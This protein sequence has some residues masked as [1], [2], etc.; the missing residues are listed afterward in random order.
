MALPVASDP[1]SRLG[2]LTRAPEAE[3]VM[4]LLP[5]A[6]TPPELQDEERRLAS[7]LVEIQRRA[8]DGLVAPILAE[9]SLDGA[10]GQALMSLA[11]AYLRV[12]DRATADALIA[13]KLA[14]VDWTDH[15]GAAG[16][17]SLMARGL[18]AAKKVTSADAGRGVKAITAPVVRTAVT[19]AMRQMGRFF[20]LGRDIAEALDRA[21]GLAPAVC[22]FDMLGEGARTREAADQYFNRYRD[23]INAVG[24]AARSEVP[25]I[26]RHSVSVK[27][28]ALHPR[29][30]VSQADR[31]VPELIE[32]VQA[33]AE[34]AAA[35][36]IALTIDAEE[37]ERLIMS[38]DIIGAVAKTPALR[39]WDGLGMAVQA[40]QK[41]AL[42]VIDWA[43]ETSRAS[44]RRLAVRLVKGAYW[45]AEIKRCQ[46]DGLRDY[47][48]FTRKS[49]T[50]VSYLACAR[51]MLE[52]DSLQP[53]FATHNALTLA[54]LL[55]WAGPRRDVEFQRLHGMGEELYH[56]L[57]ASGRLHLRI[58]APVGGHQDLLPYLVRRL[59]ENG[60]NSS[61]VHQAAAKDETQVTLLADPRE[62]AARHFGAP[63]PL[64]LPPSEMFG[65]ER[66]NSTGLDMA[67]R[68]QLAAISAEFIRA[69]ADRP[70]GAPLINGIAAEGASTPVCDPANFV[71]EVGRVIEARA[72]DITK[73][74]DIA[75][76]FHEEWSGLPVEVRAACL[77][78]AAD[79]M[80]RDR[81]PLMALLVREA[82]K[83][84][85]DALL[86]V[87]E[88]TDFCRY[89]AATAR[90]LMAV[91]ILPGPTG[92]RNELRLAGRGVF[93]CI[94]P[95]NFPLAIFIGQIAA[96]L[97]TGN[98]VVAKPAPQTPLIASAAIKLLLE[99]GVP[100]AAIQLLPGGTEVG[101]ALVADPRV[102]GIVFTGSTLAAKHIARAV[103]ADDQRAL[104]TLIA[105]T[106]GLNAMIVD[107][108]A[109]P[110]QV[111]RDVVISAFQ[112]AGQR[113][114]ALRLLCL[115]DDIA[116]EVI[117]ML[118]GAIAE[119]RVGEPEAI[120]T[121]V[122]PVI[123]ESARKRLTSYVASNAN[124]V[125][126]SYDK[127]LP[128]QGYYVAPCVI[129]FDRPE[130]LEREVFGPILHLVRWK[131]GELDQLIDRVNGR[132]FGLTMGVHSRIP[133][134]IEQVRK[135]ARVGNLYVNR[136]MIGAVVG[137]Q[138][139]G[140]E[141][142]S[143]T[144][145]KA[146][147]PHYLPRFCVERTVSTD[148]TAIGGNTHLLALGGDGE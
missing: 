11:E 72:E 10:G 134:T 148:L 71:R 21:N 73:A 133:A 100:A 109:L 93:G 79:L 68:Q 128:D 125:I 33:L 45:D 53:A 116:D 4:S 52:A 82:G 40:Y 36:G 91:E 106:G 2:G 83:T 113:C 98:C 28:S 60:A 6:Q 8:P 75:A 96:A 129:E 124:K 92:E 139:F 19:Q 105:E 70:I 16:W 89:Y 56:D 5:R 67:D 136:S 47:P 143:G 69:W 27:L 114:S 144:G 81:L 138:P 7:L 80:E 17:V 18:S 14:G 108:T 38:L 74:V 25:L 64:I 131:A 24:K 88:A 126:A 42:A 66:V 117:A 76:S 62:V 51:R 97:V 39:D 23:A 147:G 142:L 107:S 122:G 50:E 84:Q 34:C 112:S 35:R 37:T 85:A 31:C 111:V 65:A 1:W 145:P 86:E 137:V 101:R 95:W 115:Q 78:R 120:T 30:E 141:G 46:Q 119:L 26:G 49:A 43:A 57:V 132:G 20:V 44:G 130:D 90:K 94:S 12:P 118:K 140:G 29:Y 146:G 58:Y 77:D 41:R 15:L 87:R 102:A 59:L 127:P 9:F 54:T 63:N 110:E 32:R 22:S 103:A 123:D 99:A 104:T 13:S 55:T 3:V 61:F 48:V 135:R 121:D